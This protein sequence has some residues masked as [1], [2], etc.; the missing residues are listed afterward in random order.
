MY[1]ANAEFIT[2]YKYRMPLK[3][4]VSSLISIHGMDTRMIG[5]LIWETAHKTI[6]RLKHKFLHISR[7]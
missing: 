1:R 2:L 4:D 5:I 6:L 7:H 3:N